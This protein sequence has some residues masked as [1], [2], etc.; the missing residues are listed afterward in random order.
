MPF[1][2]GV[3]SKQKMEGPSSNPLRISISPAR[4]DQL[5]LKSS[6]TQ[7]LSLSN[8]L[9]RSWSMEIS[10]VVR[11]QSSGRFSGEALLRLRTLAS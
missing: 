11:G 9:P 1:G 4:I 2:L 6:E 7:V 5:S 8:I 3:G 10:V